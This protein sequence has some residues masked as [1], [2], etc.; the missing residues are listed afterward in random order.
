MTD[1]KTPDR[2]MPSS[3][4]RFIWRYSASEQMMLLAMTVATFPLLYA[5]LELPK[6]IVNDA[7]GG[8]DFPRAVLGYEFDQIPYLWLLC[9]GYLFFVVVSGLM[10]MRLNTQK[11]IV[12]E[13]L[14]R[15]LRYQLISRTLRFPLPTF[16]R[17]SQGEI[18]AIVSSE[19]EPLGGLMGD[20]VAQPVFQGGQML[21]ILLFLFIQSPWLGL[22]AAALIPLQAYIIP[23]IQRRVN[24]LNKERVVRVRHLSERIGETVNGVEDLRANNGV[25][26]ALADFSE[27]LGGLFRVRYRI[28]QLKF[29]MK[30]LNNFINHLTPFFF[31]LIG[32]ALAIN[33][34]ISIGA[35]VAAI[36]SYKD[37]AAPWK[38]LL[39]YYNRSI[40]LSLRY[41]LV[42]DRFEPDGMIDEE[43]F[44]GRPSSIPRLDKAIRFENVTIRGDSG[45]RIIDSL[46]AEI[47]AGALIGIAAPDGGA[48][49][50]LSQMLSRTCVPN[51]GRLMIG[52]HDLAQLHQE[53]VASRVGVASAAPHLFN[54]SIAENVQ[55][56][57]R[58]HPN[59]VENPD[60]LNE[61]EADELAESI[62]SGN[63]AI[64][65]DNRWLDASVAGFDDEEELRDWW[66]RLIDA[67]G[68]AD[69]LFHA[70][71]DVRI[72]ADR[73][74]ELKKA[75]VAL[76]PVI[77][78]RL[79]AEGAID[80]VDLFDVDMFNPSLTIVENITLA[81]PRLVDGQ[82]PSPR[83]VA[84]DPRLHEALA[85]LGLADRFRERAVDLL[86]ALCDTFGEI[87]P[88]H[89]IFLRL[90]DVD[91]DD[92]TAMKAARKQIAAK[93]FDSLNEQMRGLVMSLPFRLAL[94][95]LRKQRPEGLKTK[96]LAAR[97]QS[98]ATLRERLS[99]LFEPLNA[100]AYADSLP[101]FENLVFGRLS[102]PDSD[103]AMLARDIALEE[104]EKAGLRR[105]VTLLIGD[106]PAG[107]GGANLGPSARERI[108]FVRA[109]L[110][111]PDVLVLDHALA[112]RSETERRSARASMRALL[113]HATIIVLEPKL[114]NAGEFDMALTIRHGRLVEHDVQ[115]TPQIDIGDT[116]SAL[117]ELSAKMRVLSEMPLFSGVEPRQL[118]L[119]AYS[120]DW[121]SA[122]AGSR[123]FRAGVEADGAYI[124]VSGAAELQWPGHR[125]GEQP[126]TEV[127]PGRLI[128]DLS[129][130]AAWPRAFDMV[131][132]QDMRALRVGKREL[133]DLIEQD[134]AVANSLLRT[135]AGYLLHSA[136]ELRR[137]RGEDEPNVLME[138]ENQTRDG[139]GDPER[140]ETEKV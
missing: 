71:L 123:V 135:V 36:A 58:H 51:S 89:P 35:L 126:I 26:F 32:G 24:L 29:L 128:G 80:A 64:R 57:L 52:E 114:E 104:L 19:V 1:E 107:I 96:V 72:Q 43:L 68:C 12:A 70:A 111:R 67:A 130:I 134:P 59:A 101:L 16:R 56:S 139:Q 15:R 46:S 124:L 60:D 53:V 21:T 106:L 83:R 17:T 103:R 30:F 127:L 82:P 108:A 65:P 55:M 5:T 91:S 93:G 110:R 90:G 2:A 73:H 49:S 115:P 105:D 27:Q 8:E 87:S 119:L 86:C 39:D 137:L 25:A 9:G 140:P 6:T 61:A 34:E 38:E 47:P 54:A 136:E 4:F 13:R 138:I 48:R 37:L 100:D 118:R 22:A 131:V 11:G 10:K 20:A 99:D 69:E 7:V 63:S 79:E 76:R 102:E 112:S 122:R 23:L 117:D 132:T 28:Y 97:K 77:A 40:D 129:V 125:P 78:R 42:A 121:V 75:I 31:Y 44:E 85:E 14:L 94:G 88:S 62:A 116:D 50:A 41:R 120:A 84:T 98:M 95:R 18:I 113:P 45:E 33:G 92:L 66:L 3:L 74:A 133:Q 109:G 81:V